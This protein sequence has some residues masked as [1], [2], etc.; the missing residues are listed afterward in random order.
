MFL[1]RMIRGKVRDRL[2]GKAYSNV[3]KHAYQRYKEYAN[4]SFHDNVVMPVL[5][6]YIC[7]DGVR[8]LIF[9]YSL[10]SIVQY[11]TQVVQ[12]SPDIFRFVTF[13]NEYL[14][15]VSSTED[16]KPR[17][18]TSFDSMLCL[19]VTAFNEDITQ[20]Q[21]KVACV[22]EKSNQGLKIPSAACIATQFKHNADQLYT[23]Q[24]YFEFC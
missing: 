6:M 13:Y 7:V 5:D 9:E 19:T 20:M 8:T 12:L 18:Y 17:I 24:L 4:Q 16:F 1:F 11:F 14:L 15:G 23:R 21:N 22:A 3:V 2:N 10:F